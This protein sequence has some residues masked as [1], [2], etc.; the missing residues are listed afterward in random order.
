[1]V[2]ISFS[3]LN[4]I[5]HLVCFP[6]LSPHCLHHSSFIF[7]CFTPDFSS[8][9]S[10]FDQGC[11]QHPTNLFLKLSPLSYHL[12]VLMGHLFIRKEK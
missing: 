2:I 6:A 1:M 3:F 11:P 4:S 7:L 8:M 12:V 10:L 9:H 5:P